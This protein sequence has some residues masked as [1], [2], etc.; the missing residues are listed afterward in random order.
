MHL[1]IENAPVLLLL[2][3]DRHCSVMGP[4]V[5]KCPRSRFAQTLVTNYQSDEYNWYKL[6]YMYQS[7]EYDCWPA[8]DGEHPF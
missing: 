6:Q 7:D 2:I 1:L 5:P 4:R 8:E 3:V